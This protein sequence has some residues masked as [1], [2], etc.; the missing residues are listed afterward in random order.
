MPEKP[1]NGA[2]PLVIDVTTWRMKQIKAW[3]AACNENNLESMTTIIAGVVKSWPY[4]GDPADVA[5]YDDLLAQDWG[6]VA[7]EVGKKVGELFR[8]T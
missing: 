4:E 6:V 7:S 5:A 2:K 1:E 8:G 3:Q